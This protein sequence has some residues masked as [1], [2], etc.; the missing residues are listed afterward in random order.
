MLG[1]ME[2]QAE[3]LRVR[4]VL[5]GKD[6]VLGFS[7][8]YYGREGDP[9][10]I[11]SSQANCPDREAL[12]EQHD[13]LK[14]PARVNTLSALGVRSGDLSSPYLSKLQVSRQTD[15]RSISSSSWME[16]CPE[17]RKRYPDPSSQR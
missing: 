1:V 8:G 10:S 17:T 4:L 12:A 2:G 5:P 6:L 3:C 15:N 11:G 13:G 7:L 9:T 14:S 16:H